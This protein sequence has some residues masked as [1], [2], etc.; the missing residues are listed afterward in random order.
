MNQ[1]LHLPAT[2][3][4]KEGAHPWNLPDVRPPLLQW[5]GCA[6]AGRS[7]PAAIH[8]GDTLSITDD[9]LIIRSSL[10]QFSFRPGKVLRIERAGMVPWF[11]RGF[12]LEH[13]MP[14]YPP[15]VGFLP[16]GVRCRD[17][18]RELERFGY[19]VI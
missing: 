18:L 12:V 17:V 14:G 5:N 7:F 6:W 3:L 19:W 10:G 13:R 16:A 8:A 11:W 4:G 9:A 2:N 1:A 15:R